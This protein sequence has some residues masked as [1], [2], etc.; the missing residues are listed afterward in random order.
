MVK[1]L[2]ISV[3]LWAVI[4]TMTGLLT[5]ATATAYASEGIVNSFAGT[6]VA[7]NFLKKTTPVESVIGASEFLGFNPKTDSFTLVSETPSQ[8]VVRVVHG[9]INFNVMLE[10]SLGGSWTVLSMTSSI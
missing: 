9:G 4:L 8:A 7:L 6:Q 5:S 2:R 10:P 1:T 3:V